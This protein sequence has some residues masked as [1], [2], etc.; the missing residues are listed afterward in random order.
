MKTS[1][2]LIAAALLSTQAFAAPTI[3]VP[4]ASVNNGDDSM[5]AMFKI[6]TPSDASVANDG[7]DQT[8][9]GSILNGDITSTTTYYEGNVVVGKKTTTISGGGSASATGGGST[10]GTGNGMKASV[11]LTTGPF[12]TSSS[13]QGVATPASVA[14]MYGYTKQTANC[15][16]QVVTQNVTANPKATRVIAV[17]DAYYYKN[18]LSDLQVF[19]KTFN[20]PAPNLSVVYATGKQPTSSMDSWDMESAL[21]LQWAHAMAPNAKLIQVQAASN[22]RADMLLAIQVATKA[23]QAAGGGVVSMSFGTNDFTGSQQYDT[24]FN[25]PGVIYYAG[26]GDHDTPLWP[27]VSQYVV[28]VGGTSVRATGIQSSTRAIGDF[29]QEVPWIGAGAGA[30]AYVAKPAYQGTNVAG[31]FRGV[32]DIALAS[33]SSGVGAWVYMNDADFDGWI[34]V[35]GTSWAT[36]MAA[37]ITANSNT[38]STTS[39]MELTKL[40]AG[41]NTYF[42]DITTGYCGLTYGFNAT[43]GWDQC[44]GLGS[45]YNYK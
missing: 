23:V 4:P 11:A 10:T 41:K 42:T 5:R 31:N 24:Y 9:N 6:I 7:D 29:E 16:P 37:A 14:C 3:T 32:P 40:Y 15:N 19:S 18:A 1:K 22:S 34:Q 36:P 21:D 43:V 44:T 35:E 27:C 17:V 28:C 39:I 2:T 38:T 13:S 45:F 20:L 25:N 8:N 30:S 33:D 26:S 12:G